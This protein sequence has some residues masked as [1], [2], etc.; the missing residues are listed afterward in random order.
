MGRITEKQ[1][2]KNADA[3]HHFRTRQ[4]KDQGVV[5]RRPQDPRGHEAEAQAFQERRRRARSETCANDGHAQA[6]SDR[7]GEEIQGVG[8]Q[9]L[10][11]CDLAASM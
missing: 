5:D 2:G 9:S 8:L 3:A 1:K 4:A 7:I 6:I 10:R 11:S